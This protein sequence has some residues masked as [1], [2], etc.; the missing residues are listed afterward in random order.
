MT[1]KAQILRRALMKTEE[2]Y[3]TN[4]TKLYIFVLLRESPKHGYELI[5]EL[6]K[7]IGKKPSAGQI[8]PLLGQLKKKGFVVVEAKGTRGRVKKVY[9]LT[10]EGRK[11]SSL[12]LARF[13]DLMA[14]AIQQKLKSCAHCGCEIYKGAYKEKISGK[15]LDFCCKSCASSYRRR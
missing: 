7:R 1:I 2:G 5:E 6:G 9:S 13:S 4:L 10:H 15:F 3:M 11:L 8:Y 14:A 12:L